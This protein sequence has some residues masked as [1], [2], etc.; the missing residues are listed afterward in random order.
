MTWNS[1]EMP[2][3]PCMSRASRAISSALPQLVRLNRRVAGGPPPPPLHQP[4]EPQRAGE[5]QRD[6][7]LHVGELL[8]DQLVGGERAPKLLAVERIL[9]GAVP[10]D[11]SRPHGAPDDAVARIIEAAERAREPLGIGQQIL[12]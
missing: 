8:L 3:P 2:L 4:A 10:A 1:S 12:L 5:A 6:L 11:L 7:G 9:P